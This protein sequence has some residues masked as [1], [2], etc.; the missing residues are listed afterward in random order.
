[1]F[2]PAAIDIFTAIILA[3][4]RT[5]RDPLR[6]H[7]SVTS[8]ALIEIQGIPMIH[9]VLAALRQSQLINGIWLSGP[10]EPALLSD[11]QLKDR[12]ADGQLSWR[13][14]GPS[15][16]TSAHQLMGEISADSKILLTTADHP[17]LDAEI[18]NRFCGESLKS[19][20]DV[21]VGLAPYAL[22]KE[23]FPAMKKTVLRFKDGDYCGCNLFA[24]LS[25]EGRQVADFWRQIESERKKPMQLI[26]LLGWWSV[27]RY[28][29]G[30]LSLTEALEHLSKILGLRLKAIIL[31]YANAA[32][33]VD[34]IA[35]YQVIQDSL[36]AGGKC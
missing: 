23:R 9:R 5:A 34:S 19:G 14:P 15:P 10:T 2:D 22:V 36:D 17:L 4:E 20:A 31:P 26:K 12:V 6:T 7:F 33:D 3:G 13:S 11:Q 1:M 35:D 32:V 24:F 21:T 28:R 30:W 27:L 18:V 29:L 16:S 25:P 8:K